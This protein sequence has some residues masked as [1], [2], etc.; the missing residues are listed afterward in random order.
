MTSVDRTTHDGQGRDGERTPG[1]T[2]RG[3]RIA[4]YV[5]LGLMALLVVIVAV[6]AW[7]LLTAGGTRWAVGQ[8]S[9]RVPAL[10]IERV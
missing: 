9:A 3:R 2:H 1:V 8:A 5:L 6:V 10:A 7:I 4:G